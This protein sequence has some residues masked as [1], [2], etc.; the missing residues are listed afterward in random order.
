MRTMAGDRERQ[1]K[2]EGKDNGGQRKGERK[3][4]MGERTMEDNERTRI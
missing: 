2:E 3:E 4:I 1:G